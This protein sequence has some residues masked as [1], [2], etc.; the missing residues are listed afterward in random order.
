MARS[1]SAVRKILKTFFLLSSF[2]CFCIP[3]SQLFFQPVGNMDT[4]GSEI[5]TIIQRTYPPGEILRFE[6][7]Y[8]PEVAAWISYYT[9]PENHGWVQNILDRSNQFTLYIRDEILKRTLP[10]E[11][12]YL[13]G[14]ESG[15]NPYAVSKSGAAGLWQFMTNSIADYSIHVDNWIDERRD[16]RKST[17][18]ALTKL[19]HNYEKF[20]D[21]LLAIAAYNCGSGCMERALKAS[22]AGNYWDVR[23]YLPSETRA[24]IPKFLAFARISMYP[25]QYGFDYPHTL[26]IKWSFI[27]YRGVLNL[28]ILSSKSSLPMSDIRKW[29]SELKKDI[30]P[31]SGG[32][33]VLKIPS[34]Y[35]DIIKETISAPDFKGIDYLVKTIERGDTLFSIAQHT[36]TSVDTLRRHN[37]S[38]KPESLEVGSTLLIPKTPGVSLPE[39]RLKFEEMEEYAFYTVQ[40][41]DTLWSISRMYETYPEY[42]AYWNGIEVN[43]A[44]KPGQQLK[45]PITGRIE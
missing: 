4:A 24:Y 9:K 27:P 30:T 25:V 36:G 22:G 12:M 45:V 34:E 10:M 15:F 32:M 6:R 16:L 14:I 37:P 40:P 44:I 35:S 33:F 26:P 19:S 1:L 23:P 31:P 13:P 2:S 28:Q 18:G 41:G 17:E 38:V 3:A 21:W 43:H 8:N 5:P 42:I 11:L 7:E 39:S 29:H 20:G